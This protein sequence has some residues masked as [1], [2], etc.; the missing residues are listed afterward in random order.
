MVAF[1]RSDR[2]FI[3]TGQI[4]VK[5]LPNGEP[6]Q[7]TH[8]PRQKYNLAFSPDGSRIAYTAIDNGP[9]WR[10]YTVPSLGGDPTLLL[11]TPRA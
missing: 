2:T 8:D 3:I 7:L 4:Y 11:P 1:Y 9:H 10:T 5:L 6:V